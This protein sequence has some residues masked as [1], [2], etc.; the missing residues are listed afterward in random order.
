MLTCFYCIIAEGSNT[1]SIC[2]LLCSMC[3]AID[4]VCCLLILSG[5][6]SCYLCVF[7]VLILFKKSYLIRAIYYTL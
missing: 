4:T 7:C 6:K 5:K 3:F 1:E 2:L